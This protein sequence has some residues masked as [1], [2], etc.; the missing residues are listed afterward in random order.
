MP[1]TELGEFEKNSFDS[2]GDCSLQINNY[3][4]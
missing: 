3:S 4:N 1:N 2:S